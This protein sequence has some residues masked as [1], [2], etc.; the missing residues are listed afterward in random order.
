MSKRFF[1][2]SPDIGMV[3]HDTQEGAKASADEELKQCR[4]DAQFDGEWPPE[5]EDIR[6]GEV[7]EA[8]VEVPHD[9]GSC[10]Y[11]LKAVEA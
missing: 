7:K 8:I 11:T 1:S 10:D 6:W 2:Y 9:E 4:K 3:W 5:V